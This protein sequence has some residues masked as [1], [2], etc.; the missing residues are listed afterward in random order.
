MLSRSE[1]AC[2][3]YLSN[4]VTLQVRACVQ[5]YYDCWLVCDDHSCGRRTKQ[6]SVRGYQCT[7]NCHGRM[8]QEYDEAQ[9][10]AQLKYLQALFDVPR[11]QAKKGLNETA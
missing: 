6:Q 8:V 1:R 7:N 9:L 3:C 4:C 10:H 2:Y 11:L 5:R